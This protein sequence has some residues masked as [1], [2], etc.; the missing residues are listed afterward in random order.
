MAVWITVSASSRR[1]SAQSRL[2]LPCSLGEKGPQ[3]A[4]PPG[5]SLALLK[6]LFKD[7]FL[8]EV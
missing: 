2:T 3:T 7:Y 5:S 8:R 4:L 1:D 6:S